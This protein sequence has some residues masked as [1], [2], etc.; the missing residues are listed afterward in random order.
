[1]MLVF[2]RETLPTR[3]EGAE[4]PVRKDEALGGYGTVLRDR[5]FMSFV[6]LFTL[7]QFCAATVWILLSVYAK[8]QYGVSE[9]L[10]GW[11]PT[12]NALMVVFLQIAVT[13]VTRRYM[14]LPVLAFGA[15]FYAVAVGSVGIGQGFWAFWLSMVIM[16]LGELMIMPT[17]STY[18]A[19]LAPAD[20][21]GRYMSFFSLSWGA[22]SGLAPLIGGN[23]GDLLGP[24][25]TWFGA[26]IVGA[27]SVAGF[28][29]LEARRKRA[30]QPLKPA[31]G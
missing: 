11:I 10:Y 22:A 15:A 3:Q 21:R 31:A 30:M 13:A 25:S 28:V 5:H 1:L 9:N 18:I 8:H 20:M 29:L 23:L 4:T 26:A 19:N 12:T 17:A 14:P 7:V 24:H 2:A 16:T 27:I 6:G